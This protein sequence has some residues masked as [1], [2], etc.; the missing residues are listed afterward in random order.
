MVRYGV[1]LLF[2]MAVG[3]VFTV[4]AEAYESSTRRTL[5]C[6]DSHCTI[7]DD[8]GAFGGESRF[9]YGDVFEPQDISCDMSWCDDVNNECDCCSESFNGDWLDDLLRNSEGFVSGDAFKNVGDATG[10]LGSLDNSQGFRLGVNS[11]FR[12]GDLPFRGQFGVGYGGYDWKGRFG[13][14]GLVPAS[15]IEKQFYVTAGLFRR[16]DIESGE[17]LSWG[18]VY[19]EF[20]ADQW[21]FLAQD[22]S[23]GQVRG[24]LGYALNAANEVGLR[25]AFSAQSGNA[26]T[27]LR[28]GSPAFTVKPQDQLNVFWHHHW[29]Y[30]ADTNFFAGVVNGADLGDWLF[31]FDA[32]APLNDCVSVYGGITYVAPSVAAGNIGVAQEAWNASIGFVI[33][34]GSKSAT[35]NVS[36]FHGMPLLPVADNGSMIIT[37]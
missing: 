35:R 1:F 14:G 28:A 9:D 6:D 31:G 10:T 12:L 25:G 19:D 5:I 8:D 18:V 15:A 4:R 11:G 13:L 33:S 32:R 34:L 20:V 16:S 36:G 21:G 24:S 29:E 7:T 22:F 2:L 3:L 27:F 23:V 37:N 26:L 17:R 30:G